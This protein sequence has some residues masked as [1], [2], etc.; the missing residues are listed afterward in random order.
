MLSLP[1]QMLAPYFRRPAL[2]ACPSL[3]LPHSWCFLTVA[4]PSQ[5]WLLAVA[6]LFV[7]IAEFALTIFV[8]S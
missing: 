1:P 3:L 8:L 7:A 6:V 5:L 4:A 2:R